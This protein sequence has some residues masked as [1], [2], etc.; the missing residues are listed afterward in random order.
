MKKLAP[1]FRP[2]ACFLF[3]GMLSQQPVQAQT[4]PQNNGSHSCGSDFLLRSMDPVKLQDF[5]QNMYSRVMSHTILTPPDTEQY[6]IPIAFHILHQN[7][8]ENIPDQQVWDAFALINNA[9]ANQ[10][11]FNPS[12]STNINVDF[13]LVSSLISHHVSPLTNM[14]METEDYDVKQIGQLDPTI[15]LNIWVVNSI[16][17]LNMGPNVAGYAMMPASHGSTID[18]IVIE[19]DFITNNPDD[20]KV[21]AHEIGH[22]LGLYHTFEG[23]CGNNDCMTD[24]DKVCDTPPDNS[25]APV[26]CSGS[27]NTCHSDSDDPSVNNPFRDVSLGGLGDQPDMF[28]NYMDYGFQSCQTTFTDGQRTRMRDV[29]RTIR[30]SLLEHPTY[31]IPCPAPIVATLSI[32][33]TLPAGVPANFTVNGADPNFFYFWQFNG[34]TATGQTVTQTIAGAA[35]VAVTVYV[36]NTASPGCNLVLRDTVVFTCIVPTPTFTV[37]PAGLTSPGQNIT[38]TAPNTGYSYT[39][40]IDGVAIGTG[41][42]FNY[43][44]TGDYGRLLTLV[45]SN[46]TCQAVSSSYYIDPNNCAGSKANS[47]WYFGSAAGIDFNANPPQAIQGKI[48]TEEGC[49]VISDAVTGAPIFHSDGVTVGNSQTG[50]TLQN[51]TG[52]T[53]HSTTTQSAMFVPMPGSSRYVY[54]FT[55]DFQAGDL[56][57]FAGGIYYSIIDRQGDGGNGSV[58]TKN[59]LLL[60]PVPEKVTAVKNMAGDGIWVISHQWNSDAFYAW[61]ITSTGIGAPVISHTGAI[62]TNAPTPYSGRAALGEMKASPSGKKIAV[63]YSGPN[64]LEIFDFNTAT[65]VLSNPVSIHS[66][67]QSECY[68]VA[69]SPNE[70]FLYSSAIGPTN[71]I[72]FDLSSGNSAGIL[73]SEAL[74]CSVSSGGGGALQLA[75][76]GKIYGARR[77]K[78]YLAVISNPNA[79]IP[80]NCGF[81][82]DGFRL[83]DY[84]SSIYGLPN[85][86]QSVLLSVDPVITGPDKICLNGA[87]QSVQYTFDPIGNATY[88][89]VHHGPNTFS[90]VNTSTASINYHT[91]GIDTL[92]VTRTAPCGNSYDTL[93]ITSG[94]APAFDIGPDFLVCPGTPVTINATPG[95]FDYH[96]NNNTNLPTNTVTT[97]GK[98]RV[99]MI[100]QSGCVLKDSLMV[101][102]YSLPGLNLGNDTSICTAEMLTLTAPAGASS[103]LWSN[104]ATSNSIMVSDSGTYVVTVGKYG[105]LFKDTILVRKDVLLHVIPDTL[106]LCGG[107]AS[108]YT[109]P[110]GFDSY[111]WQLPSGALMHTDTVSIGDPGYYILTYS[112]HCGSATDSLL[113]YIPRIFSQDT[114]VSCAD[115]I[116]VIADLPLEAIGSSNL[117]YNSYI[118]HGDTADIYRSGDYVGIIYYP[119]MASGCVLLQN[120]T[121]LVDTALVMPART[122]NLGPDATY[123]EG[124]VL[125]LNAGAGFETYHWNTGAID[126]FTTVYGFG[127]YSVTARYCGF[128]YVDTIVITRDSSLTVSLGPDQSLCPPITLNLDAGSGFDWYYWNNGQTGQQLTVTNSGQFTIE[129]GLNGCIARDTI[130]IV[131]PVGLAEAKACDDPF[132]LTPNPGSDRVA[133]G[134]RCVHSRDLIVSITGSDGRI[135]GKKE[136]DLDDVNFFMNK[137]MQ[138][139]SQGIYIV[140]IVAGKKI[141]YLK[142]MILK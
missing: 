33:D 13:C 24:G 116:R 69:F 98:V 85:P 88:T 122:I 78:K 21:L 118:L 112:N 114:L 75:P 18:G 37:T 31:C 83:V 73:A 121:V 62:H 102:Y 54:L 12:A 103:Y 63:A 111:S 65:G 39:W 123:C 113:H 60:A 129:V 87:P 136:G 44:V 99:E 1:L 77:D 32:P 38:F 131:C 106:V 128:D 2:F 26:L 134:A 35:T 110:S 40:N 61:L 141:Y 72:R 14:T 86:V 101:V 107:S 43:T 74:I 100:T 57:S 135:L 96:W 126:S 55:V 48:S 71:I 9:F 70:R 127:A 66:T 20:V 56:S 4:Q 27:A 6:T 133:L 53:G 17:S 138:E 97:D 41:T 119:D 125:P 93:F 82:L 36:I 91:T 15:Y 109:A 23:G 3:F 8:A 84:T 80:A 95:M 81:V 52:L 42:T 105:C 22:Y 139:M 34:Q 49:S 142:W 94:T 90:F 11:P 58:T 7:G 67:Q 130:L 137:M 45:A 46:G 50:F 124:Y 132:Y 64:L 117:A 108:F 120:I 51:G 76:D 29:L 115:T 5:E 92:I 89:W 19:A 104:G 79:V 25:I 16:Y 30:H 59:Q 47:T 28:R 140:K 10:V 68:G